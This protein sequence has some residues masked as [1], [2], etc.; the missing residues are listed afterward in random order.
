MTIPSAVNG[1][2]DLKHELSAYTAIASV[3]AKIRLIRFLSFALMIL[4]CFYLFVS[5]NSAVVLV[6]GVVVL[7]LQGLGFYS[8]W[9]LRKYALRHNLLLTLGV[10]VWFVTAWIVYERTRGAM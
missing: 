7:L 6:A 10:L 2:E 4:A 5:H 1:F 9:R 3:K 8:I